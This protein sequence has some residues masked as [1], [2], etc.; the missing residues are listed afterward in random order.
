MYFHSLFWGEQNGHKPLLKSCLVLSL[1]FF[2]NVFSSLGATVMLACLSVLHHVAG[3]LLCPG[4]LMHTCV[5]N[6][7]L[8]VT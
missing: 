6:E 1:L 5:L 8:Q 3:S 7:L 4:P 2:S